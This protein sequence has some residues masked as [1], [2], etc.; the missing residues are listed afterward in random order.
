[1]KKMLTAFR[2]TGTTT[3]DERFDVA[4]R[5]EFVKA[6]LLR[7]NMMISLIIGGFAAGLFAFFYIREDVVFEQIRPV[8]GSFSILLTG[9]LVYELFCRHYILY[10]LNR[11]LQLQEWFNFGNLFIEA[12]F[13]TMIIGLFAAKMNP[14]VVFISPFILF[15]FLFIMH[16]I[17]HLQ[18]FSGIFTG[19]VAA[20]EYFLL[21][22]Y[23]LHIIDIQHADP[24]VISSTLIII[25]TLIILL[26]G[27]AAAYI[28]TEIKHR[29]ID[30][31]HTINEKNMIRHIFG[32]QVSHEIVDDILKENQ[33][34]ST[35][36]L[37]LCVMFVD[38]RNFTPFAASKTPEEVLDFQ[39]KLFANMIDAINKNHG[40]IHQIMGDGLMASF[41]APVSHG[42][43]CANAVRAGEEI[44]GAT[45]KLVKEK[46]I[47]PTRLGVGIHYGT[48]VTGQIGTELRKQYSIVG[49]VVIIASRIEQL[50]KEYNSQ[51]LVS[52]TVFEKLPATVHATSLG[53]VTLKG[54]NEPL[55]IMRLR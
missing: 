18:F 38:V 8:M 31:Y 36:R 5:L 11:K 30:T 50:N 20:A 9:M 49:N 46:E 17:L 26:C 55:E 34:L 24:L 3:P 48:A 54:E 45:E 32:Q 35:K 19:V 15:Y 53:F 52:R 27:I 14:L 28:G 12:S 47:P 13:P 1:M 25:R 21:S 23:V 41:G 51:F 7:V 33:G 44:L 16:S 6:E 2:N 22:N 37:P 29:V 39:N 4:F 43:D 40:I 42:N 10:R